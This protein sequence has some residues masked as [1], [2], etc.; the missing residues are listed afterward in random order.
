MGWMKQKYELTL[1]ILKSLARSQSALARIIDSMAD[2]SEA[3]EK[4]ASR[5]RDHIETL[6][7]YQQ[8]ITAKI[9]GVSLREVKTSPPSRPW[10]NGRLRVTGG[11][12]CPKKDGEQGAP[13]GDSDTTFV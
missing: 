10:T 1:D 6:V 11:T 12:V 7:R 4:T 2:V 9:T 3:D 13:R 5:L 8:A